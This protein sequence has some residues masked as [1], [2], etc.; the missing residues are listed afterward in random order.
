[1]FKNILVATDGSSSA[2]QAVKVAGNLARELGADLW[3]VTAFDPIPTYLAEPVFQNVVNTQM[4]LAGHILNEAVDVAGNISGKHES[5]VL[6]GPAAIAILREAEVYHTDLII[7][8][9][10]A[11]DL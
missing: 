5:K 1:M 11:W 8:V 3:I 4:E 9:H 7:M 6:E 2:T 10:A